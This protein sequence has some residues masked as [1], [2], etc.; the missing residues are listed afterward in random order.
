MAAN[1]EESLEE[2]T[3]GEELLE[4]KGPVAPRGLTVEDGSEDENENSGDIL[5]E[6]DDEERNPLLEL[7]KCKDWLQQQKINHEAE[8]LVRRLQQR[9]DL[10]PSSSESSQSD[11]YERISKLQ[12]QLY[13]LST[14]RSYKKLVLDR[15]LCG[16]Q[17]IKKLFPD[18]VTDS[19]TE[20]QTEEMNA[21]A[22]LC[23]KQNKLSSE[24]LVE[25]EVLSEVQ[26]TLDRLKQQSYEIKKENRGLMKQIQKLRDEKENVASSSTDNATMQKLKQQIALKVEKID[27][28]RNVFQ[29][30]IVG[31]GIDW[32]SD[33]E[34]RRLVL[35]LGETLEFAAT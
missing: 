18:V 3:M 12:D 24:I 13:S 15:L 27:I 2:R 34:M 35:S 1:S 16:D 31:S 6:Q 9:E 29:G 10:Q 11:L 5:D 21:F 33:D 19:P 23:E 26:T 22:K 14:A 7:K 25:H 4:T 32:A 17:L 28:V 8:L 20:E 30:L